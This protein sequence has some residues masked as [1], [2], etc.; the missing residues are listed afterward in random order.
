MNIWI[1]STEVYELGLDETYVVSSSDI[2]SFA[3]K[4]KEAARDIELNNNVGHSGQSLVLSEFNPY[5]QIEQINN[6]LQ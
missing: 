3:K 1:F 4:L 5:I 2:S 6:V